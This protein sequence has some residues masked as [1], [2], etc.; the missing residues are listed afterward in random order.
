M[1]WEGPA[2][3]YGLVLALAAGMGSAAT[4][5]GAIRWYDDYSEGL[6]V[7]KKSGR[8]MVVVFGLEDDK[9]RAAKKLFDKDTLVPFHRLFV[10]I[11]IGITIKDRTVTHALFGKYPPGQGAITFPLI[12]FADTD[13]KVLSKVEG[14][15]KATD[16]ASEMTAALK[17]TGGP[18]NL[19]K[20]RDAQEAFDR[21]NA[22]AAKK[23]YGAAGKLYKEV[24]DLNLKL[25]ATETAKKELAKIEEMAK[26]QLEAARAD[27]ADK[28]YPEAVRKLADLEETFSP[29]PAAREARGELAKLRKLPEA[30]EAF[31]KAERKEA[32]VARPAPKHTDDPNDIENDYF[33]D[34]ELDALDK[35]AGGEEARP[36]A[37]EAGPAAECRRLLTLARSWIANNQPAKARELLEKIIAKYPDGPYASQAEALLKSLAPG[38]SR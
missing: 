26:K 8:P 37:K 16:L 36:A 21:A 2:A 34:E 23:Q 17:K 31:E 9:T 11:H 24:V 20:T 30:K 4:A 18:V 3:R 25:P 6:D 22:L 1:R 33:T 38:S 15:Q 28:A 10:F 14:S 32:V 27:V 19:K 5:R 12:F 35:M 29:L 7:A 13:E